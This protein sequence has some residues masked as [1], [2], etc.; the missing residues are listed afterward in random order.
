MRDM[1]FGERVGAQLAAKAAKFER[2][3]RLI[4]IPWPK[5][6]LDSGYAGRHRVLAI[7]ARTGHLYE[8][9]A[10]YGTVQS[11]GPAATV[12]PV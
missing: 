4:R 7:S 10:P 6:A 8:G 1:T 2:E 11:W 9:Y 12:R 5:K 3:L